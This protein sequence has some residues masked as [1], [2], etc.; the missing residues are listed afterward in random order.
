MAGYDDWL[1]APLEAA[2]AEHD[3]EERISDAL[4]SD[5]ADIW[6]DPRCGADRAEALEMLNDQPALEGF[7]WLDHIFRCGAGAGDEPVE[8]VVAAALAKMKDLWVQC[9][10]NRQ[11]MRNELRNDYDGR[12]P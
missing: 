2:E 12:E 10:R 4:E 11:R 6:R 7:D 5:F 1:V 3:A 9:P 8:A